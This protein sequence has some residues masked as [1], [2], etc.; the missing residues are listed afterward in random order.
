MTRRKQKYPQPIPQ[1]APQTHITGKQLRLKN[2]IVPKNYSQEM[3]MQSLREASITV[4]EGPAGAGKTYL[5]V[6]IAIEK[7]LNNEVSKI[8]LTRPVVE[9]DEKLGFLPG[10]LKEKLD[11]YLRPLYDAIEDH[12]GPAGAKWL[13]ESGKV[14]IAPLAYM[15]GR[16]FNNAFV[17]LDEA[18]N[19][20]IKQI[21]MFLTRIGYNSIYC[22]DGDVTQSDLP[23]PRGMTAATFEN[24]L[25]Y[26]I[27]K[28]T[29]GKSHFVNLVKF[30]SRDIVRSDEAKEMVMLLD[31]P[32][33]RR[34]DIESP[35]K[36]TGYRRAPTALFSL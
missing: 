29:G 18:Q 16:T 2:K 36:V 11:P 1:S 4:G 28:I 34:N 8:V 12:L 5:V 3:Y 7:L 35:I 14:E 33:E 22:V 27:R 9:S 25:Q 19:A 32:D 15:R 31:A 21:K 10:T 17:I 26:A 30:T 13:L 6:G 23:I 20:T 24:G